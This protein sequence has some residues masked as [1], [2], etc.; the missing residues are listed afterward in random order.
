MMQL[1]AK[2]IYRYAESCIKFFRPEKYGGQCILLVIMPRQFYHNCLSL[3]I[4]HCSSITVA[5][6]S[7]RTFLDLTIQPAMVQISATSFSHFALHSVCSMGH[8]AFNTL[9]N[10]L[11]T[12]V[13]WCRTLLL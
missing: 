8:M 6:V 3:T 5:A 11:F 10:N 7:S 9:Y 12:N 1:T 4:S 13:L 2:E